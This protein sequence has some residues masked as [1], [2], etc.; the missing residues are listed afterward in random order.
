MSR[1]QSLSVCMIVKN[2]AS[3]LADALSSF[4][5]FADEIVVVDTG[6]TDGTRDIAVK[7]TPHVYDFEWI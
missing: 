4:K 3:N 7:F 1:G 6:S 5:S 2:E